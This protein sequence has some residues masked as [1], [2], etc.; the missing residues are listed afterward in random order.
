ML[1]PDHPD[2]LTTRGNLAYML[3]EA[4]QPGQAAAQVRDL[5]TDFLRVLG[6]DH[7]GT[8]TARANLAYMLGAAG[9]PGQAAAQFRDAA[10]RPAAGAGTRP[11]RHP[12]RPRQPRLLAGQAGDGGR[13]TFWW[14]ASYTRARKLGAPFWELGTSGNPCGKG[15]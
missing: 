6:P 14:S 5:L 2:T 8:L 1:G 3:G 13:L 4:G 12:R 9:Q 15:L 10:H 7:P 11:P